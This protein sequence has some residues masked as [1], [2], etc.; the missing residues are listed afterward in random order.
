MTYD[1]AVYTIRFDDEQHCSAET[2]AGIP[3]DAASA[4]TTVDVTVINDITMQ[5][6]VKAD[7]YVIPEFEFEMTR[8]LPCNVD[9]TCDVTVGVQSSDSSGN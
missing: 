4:L 1:K 3:H 9:I 5:V 7:A 6:V 8:Q 2:Y